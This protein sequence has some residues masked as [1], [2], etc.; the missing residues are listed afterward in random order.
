MSSNEDNNQ[1]K[2]STSVE[3][4]RGELTAQLEELLNTLSNKFAGV[5]SEIFAKMDEM[6]RRLDNIEAQLSTQPQDNQG[7]SK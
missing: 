5:S 6:S 3:D 4:P 7:G 1:A 2:S